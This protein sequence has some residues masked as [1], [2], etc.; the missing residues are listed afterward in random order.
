MI[1]EG[2]NMMG[3]KRTNRSAALRLLHE[4]GG[5]SRKRLAECTKLTPAAIT[6][7]AGEMISEG[8]I[9]EGASIVGGGAGR[10][11]VTLELRPDARYALG[12]LINLRQAIISAVRL[13]GSVIFVEEL[14]IEEKCAA[15]ETVRALSARICQLAEENRLAR[16]KII[17]LGIA[18]RGITSPDGRV[19]RNSFGALDTLNYPLCD[20]FEALT[21]LPCVMANNV[22]ALF[23]AQ[24]FFAKDNDLS[25]QFFLRCEYGIGASLSI[26]G[27]IWCGSSQQCAEIGHIPVVKRG[28]RPC[29]CGKSGCLETVASPT[30]ILTGA[31]ELLSPEKTPVLWNICGGRDP[32]ELT[33]E[34]VFNAAQSGDAQIAALV[35]NAAAALA[36]ALK[37]VI[38][39]L[40]PGKLVLYGRMFEN[41]YYLSKLM[42][43]MREGVDAQH[44]IPIEKSKYNKKLEK[45]AAGLLMVERFFESGGLL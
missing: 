39:T 28:G 33:I 10:R 25:S 29:S 21:G 23:A 24:M 43:E 36:S 37:S 44:N 12:V 45:A 35:E 30:A 16:D 4:N 41:P 14:A 11:E 2:D 31:L 18:I 42:A 6:K 13:D 26:D 9:R 7:I 5:M 38:Y 19:V 40:D 32:S 22:R 3:I 20:K 15:D 27:R 34:D 17:G 8:L 1:H